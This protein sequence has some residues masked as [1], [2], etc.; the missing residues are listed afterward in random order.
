M[1]LCPNLKL[2]NLQRDWGDAWYNLSKIA[3]AV[4][5][6]V[7]HRSQIAALMFM[8][9]KCVA[10]DNN[11]HWFLQSEDLAEEQR[12]DEEVFQAGRSSHGDNSTN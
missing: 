11:W 1:M 4:G 8:R 6:H 12:I 2:L 7:D 9:H 5:Y 10:E 3:S